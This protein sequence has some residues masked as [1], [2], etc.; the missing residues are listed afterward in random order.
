M[1]FNKDNTIKDIIEKLNDSNLKSISF[2]I[3]SIINGA[4]DITMITKN[5]YHI[6][7]VVS[8]EELYKTDFQIIEYLTESMTHELSIFDKGYKNNEI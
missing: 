7:K 6:R 2:N 4:I 1:I 8:L 5:N 3:N